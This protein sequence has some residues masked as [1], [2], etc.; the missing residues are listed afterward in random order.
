MLVFRLYDHRIQEFQ[1][2]DVFQCWMDSH[3]FVNQFT[4]SLRRLLGQRDEFA[5]GYAMLLD[6]HSA[7]HAGLKRHNQL[8]HSLCLEKV[9]QDRD[10]GREVYLR[11][12]AT[13]SN[14]LYQFISLTTGLMM[15]PEAELTVTD[16]QS[17][18]TLQVASLR[19]LPGQWATINVGYGDRTWSKVGT[20]QN[21]ITWP[22]HTLPAEAT[23]GMPQA[24]V[25][26]TAW[27]LD[28]MAVSWFT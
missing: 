4:I 17:L 6:V 10:C 22:N 8:S 14:L 21:G 19:R 7:K 2:I 25:A 23:R 12:E 27:P 24:F 3:L 1:N 15:A 13:T 9:L 28:R 18:D 11:W 16:Q 20:R 5:G 26:H